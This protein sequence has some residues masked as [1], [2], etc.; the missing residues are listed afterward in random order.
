M[1]KNTFFLLC[2]LAYSSYAFSQ[3]SIQGIVRDK[4]TKESIVGAN[5]YLLGTTAGQSTNMEGFYRLDNLKAGVYRVVVSFISYKSDT[6]SSVRVQDGK[7]T[8]LDF[9]IEEVTTQ[10]TGVTITERK[11]TDT[12]ISII[13]SIKQSNQIVVGVSSQQI[14]KSQDK[15]ASEVIRRLPGVTITDGR[16]VIVRG[17][18][19]RYNSVWLNNAPAPSTETDRRAFSF[20]VIPSN[21]INNILI[22]KTPAPEIPADFAGAHIQIFTK[23]QPEE[24]KISRDLFVSTC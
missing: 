10:L 11:K 22:Y 16:F 9:A 8:Q 17:L 20:D 14:A 15:D 7:T 12:D 13:S 6:L 19:E 24:N 5:V 3:G 18:V 21:L 2:L 23:N 1:K 4:K